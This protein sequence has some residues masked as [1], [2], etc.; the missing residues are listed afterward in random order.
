MHAPFR[1]G[2]LGQVH[3]I[4]IDRAIDL[5]MGSI[6]ASANR[7]GNGFKVIGCD[8]GFNRSR[9]IL[10]KASHG[11]VKDNRIEACWGEAVKVSP[12]Y[13]WLESGSSNDVAITGNTITN[14]LGK[15]IAVYAIAGKG[16]MAPTGAHNNIVIENNTITDVEDLHIWVSST[17]GLTLKDNTYDTTKLKLENCQDVKR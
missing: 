14:C 13:W 3:E 17:K 5:P 11:I 10:I 7:M 16:G 4:E 9:G 6:I 1:Q 2:K 8:F 12:E 15:G